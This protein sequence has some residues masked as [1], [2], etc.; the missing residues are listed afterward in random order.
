MKSINYVDI[1]TQLYEH[2]GNLKTLGEI[3]LERKH[4]DDY[5]TKIIEDFNCALENDYSSKTLRDYHPLNVGLLCN[6][7]DDNRDLYDEYRDFYYPM[8]ADILNKKYKNGF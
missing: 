5:I 3:Q 6:T 7:Y 2:N 4:L 1:M 8:A